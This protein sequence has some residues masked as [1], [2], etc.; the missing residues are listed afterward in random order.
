ASA[1]LGD[2]TTVLCT[3]SADG[4]LHRH[5]A[6]SGDPIGEPTSTDWEP[7]RWRGRTLPWQGFVATVRCEG[8][9]L[10]AVAEHK[11]SV[12][13]WDIRSGIDAGTI[14]FPDIYIRGLAATQLP[15]GTPL[16]VVSD[17]Q[18]RV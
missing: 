12:Q 7:R 10:V 6:S 5:D 2:G 15:D 14:Y 11:T 13:L 9:D 3:V 8:R 18:G 1:V 16:L 17:S 4:V